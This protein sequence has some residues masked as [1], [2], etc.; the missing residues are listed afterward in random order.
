[1]QAYSVSS[2]AATCLY[3]IE[4][5]L[6][7]GFKNAQTQ[8][9]KKKSCRGKIKKEFLLW[10]RLRAALVTAHVPNLKEATGAGMRVVSAD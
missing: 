5:D 4:V 9:K 7:K 8:P 1:M 6:P 2:A 10:Q 3:T